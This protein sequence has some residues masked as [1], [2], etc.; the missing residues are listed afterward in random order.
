MEYNVSYH[1]NQTDADNNTSPLPNNY[2][3]GTAPSE[4][5]VVRVENAMDASCYSTAIVTLQVNALPT[6]TSSVELRQ[7]DN[8]SDGI[9]DFNLTEANDLIS[10]NAA[11]ETFTYYTNSADANMAMNEITNPTAYTNT[12]P[13][14]NPDVLF[15][16]VENA[17]GCY[18]VAQLELFVSASQIPN[19]YNLLY[20]AC[21]DDAVDGD[22]TNGIT[23]FDFSD[24]TPQIVALFGA[25]QDIT[26]TYYENEADALAEQNAIPDISNHRNDA[27]PFT[28]NIYVRVD[29]NTDNSCT[30]LGHHI[31]LTTINPTPNLD[32]DDLMLCDDI[33]IGDLQ[34][35]FDLTVNET[36]IF[37]GDP[38]VFATYY[39][40]ANDAEMGANMIPNPTAYT[41]TNPTETIYVRVENS[42]SGCYARVEFDIT[43]YPLPDDSVT[44]TDFPVC[45]NNTD[46]VFPFDLESKTT[47]ILNGQDPN[48]F[49]VTYHDSQQD[50]DDVVDALASPYN[51]TSN[52]QQI[53]VA[54]TNITTGC[55]VSTL[56][57]NIEVIEG[58][59][60]NSDGEP[61]IY[62]ICDNVGDNDGFGQF[63]LTTQDA[64]VLDGQDPMAFTLTYHDS[65]DDALNNVEPLPTLYENTSVN[66][67]PANPQ[68]IYARVSNNLDPDACFEIAE[69][70][71]QVNLQPIFDIDDRYV[72]CRN[73][74][75]SEVV[76]VPPV[77]DTQ[78][79]DAD[80]SFEWSLNGTVIPT[81]TSSSLIPTQGGTYSVVVTDTST[82]T[83][84]MCSSTDSTEVIESEP[85][86]VTAEVTSNAFSGNNRI[87]ATATGSSTYEF[88]LDNGPWQDNGS[89]EDV[90]AG[91][92]VVLARDINGCGIG[93]TTVL[94]ID[95]P[96]YFT[97]NGDGNHESWNIVGI[98]TQ[99]LA[100]V[101]I[102]DR[103]GKLLKQL[104]PQ[105]PGWDG[106]YRGNLMPTSDYWFKV[107]YDEPRTGERK[108]FTA[109]F[110]LKR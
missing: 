85:P 75:G 52:P 96:K 38:D 48:Q 24:A 95:Y 18:R 83:V 10:A 26:V 15:V 40:T 84:T 4:Q 13:S 41:N 106:T 31:T 98:D 110:S 19:G 78:L 9:S 55:S 46:F 22:N 28:Q 23:T 102:F 5:I 53:F 16:R 72:L 30:G 36:Y 43:V 21:D 81:E 1:D 90:S 25:G 58:A 104:D 51:N 99:P 87:E 7:C 69:V 103:Y 34:E 63:D 62:E 8:D 101:Y 54:I 79:S 32:P 60:A 77:I 2:T 39:L 50:A 100:K 68:V 35:V 29:N 37:N 80:Y 70:T 27:S 97:P 105:G 49:T 44:V 93:T 59:E 11:N 45:E 57:F 82:S 56:N 42:N 33:T 73:V 17:D 66:G 109:H 61:L 108:E 92:H 71:L 20:E 6:I 12:D 107:E 86:I 74:N 14:A 47:E 91:E 65:M 67:N 94:V 88:S 3:N 64:E 89:F 76:D